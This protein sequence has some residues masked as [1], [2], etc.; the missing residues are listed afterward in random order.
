MKKLIGLFLLVCSSLTFAN[1]FI[2]FGPSEYSDVLSVNKTTVE[3]NVSKGPWVS[4]GSVVPPIRILSTRKIEIDYKF[5]AY[6]ASNVEG[7]FIK[8]EK[9]AIAFCRNLADEEYHFQNIMYPSSLFKLV[10]GLSY[11]ITNK[12]VNPEGSAY[13]AD[14]KTACNLSISLK[15]K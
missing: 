9:E 11:S 5:N 2:D 14:L 1:S 6:T 3:M 12:D 7:I 13:L 4:H 8:L 15:E 10:V